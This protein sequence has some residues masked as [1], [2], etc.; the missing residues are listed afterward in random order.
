MYKGLRLSIKWSILYF[1]LIL[2][3]RFVFVFIP[4]FVVTGCQ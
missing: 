1:P 3:K 2:L 4:I